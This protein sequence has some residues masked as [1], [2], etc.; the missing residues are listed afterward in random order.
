MSQESHIQPISRYEDLRRITA[1][2][3]MP[4]E[5]PAISTS[6]V[7]I[8]HFLPPLSANE[9]ATKLETIEFRTAIFKSLYYG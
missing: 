3:A 5:K 9:Q 7:C 8:M 6:N 4:V 1:A 2:L